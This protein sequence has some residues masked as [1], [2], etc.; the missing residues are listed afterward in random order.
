MRPF[1]LD[2]QHR[3]LYH[4][5]AVTACGHLVALLEAS[6]RMMES[7][8]LERGYLLPLMVQTIENW[9][10]QGVPAMTGPVVRRDDATLEAD[11]A[12]V[13]ESRPELLPLWDALTDAARS[14]SAEWAEPSDR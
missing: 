6:A 1:E 7:A 10:R 14:M 5:A 3:P 12:A 4:A 2:D 9:E 8:G 13:A 11:R